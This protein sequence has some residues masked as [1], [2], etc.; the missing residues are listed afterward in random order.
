MVRTADTT[1]GASPRRDRLTADA[2]ERVPNLLDSARPRPSYVLTRA[3]FLRLLGGVYLFAYLSLARQLVPL[4]GEH[5]LQPVGPVGQA[6]NDGGHADAN[7]DAG[8]HQLL[9][10]A[11]TLFWM[12]SSGLGPAPD[13]VVDRWDADCD[14]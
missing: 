11:Q 13:L 8:C 12:S 10:R 2:D 6:G 9:D 7:V 4:L 5:G 1:G 3:V 14:V